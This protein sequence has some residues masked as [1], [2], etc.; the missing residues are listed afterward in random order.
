MATS[1][2]SGG[3][4]PVEALAEEFL[5]RKRRGEPASP[6][7]YAE[8]HP[9]LAEEILVLFPALLMMEDLAGDSGGQTGSL[10]SG[11][12]TVA[13]ATAGRLGEF[14]LLREVGRGGMGVVY[15][16]EQESLGRRVALKVLPAGALVDAKQV[17]RFER[18]ARSAARLHHTNIVPVFGV[19]RHEGTHFYVMQF[20]Q[21]QGL[22]AVLDELRR[23][24]ESRDPKSAKAGPPI[25]AT[26]SLRQRD[27]SEIARS[28]AT[29]RF[30]AGLGHG[31]LPPGTATLPWS[32]AGPQPIGA[33]TSASDLSNSAATSGVTTLPETDRRFALGV[34]RIGVQ[35]AEALAYAH[36]QGIL[37]RDI[38]PSNLLLDRDGNVW[39][40]DFG[41]AKATGGEDLTHTGDVVG[42]VRYMAPERFR[43]EGD[44]RAD[45]YS[46][47]LTLYE[48]LALRPAFEEKD[49]AA[50]VRQVTQEDPPRL[51]RLNGRV[52]ADLETIVHKAIAREPAQRYASAKALAE[53]LQ[54]FLE[55]RPILARRV[56]P[57]ERAWRWCRRNPA[58]AGLLG[59]VA[60]LVVAGLV[61]LSAATVHLSRT[62]VS[63]R[64]ARQEADRARTEAQAAQRE[65]D[66]RRREAEASRAEAE[67]QSKAAEASFARARAAVDESFTKISESRLLNVAGMQP[68]RRELLQSA[69]AYYEGFLKDHGDDPTVRAGLASAFLHVGKIRG[70]FGQG[71][72][73]RKTLEKARALFE[74]L[75]AANPADPEAAHGL[76]Q[77]LYWL[78][79]P[80]DAI[81]IWERM[82]RPGAPRFQRELAD[83]YNALGVDAS[84][85]GDKAKALDAYQK[86]LVIREML[87]GLDTGDP[88][89][90]RDLGGCLNNIGVL[91][92]NIGQPEQALALYRRGAQQA[93]EAFARAPQD[94]Q[95]G[96]FLALGLNNCAELEESLG[97]RDEATRL[98]RGVIEICET[99]VRDNPAIPWLR[100]IL[101]QAY[102]RLAERFRARGQADEAR[103]TIRAG[104]ER[105]ERLPRAG[106]EDLYTL[107]SL[108]AE[109][110][111]WLSR[112][113]SDEP[114]E[115]ERAEQ[116]RQVDLAMDALRRAA[117]A[118]I[119][120]V[121]QIRTSLP[122]RALRKRPDFEA[123]VAEL[124]REIAAPK[125]AGS[126]TPGPVAV[127]GPHRPPS[128]AAAGRSA[129]GQENQAAARHAVGLVLLD[130]GRLDAAAEHLEQ[131]LAVRRALVEA[132]PEGLA[133]QTDL[134]AT[135]AGLARLDRKAGR[136]ER[137]RQSWGQA[138]PILA[139]AV[140][141]RPDDRLAWRDLG[142]TRAELGQAEAAAAFARLIEL[143]PESDRAATLMGLVRHA[144]EAGW[145]ERARHWWEEI[146]S[147]RERAVARHPGDREAWR[148]LG[149]AR[150]ELGREDEAV[151]A[152]VKLMELTPESRDP[153]RWWS[154]DPAGI[155]E[156]LAGHDE[157]F[158]RLVRA[159]P[160]D[161]TLL[162]ARFQYLGRRKR[163]KEADEMAGRLVELEP[164]DGSVRTYHRTLLLL[165][166][167][168]EGY[169][170]ATSEALASTASN[171]Q[172]NAVGVFEIFGEFDY[173]RTIAPDR[174]PQVALELMSCG[175]VAYRE[176]RYAEA[177]G[178]LEKGVE[179]HDDWWF[180]TVAHPFMAMA[181]QKLGHD[182]E[183]RRELA[184]ARESYDDCRRMFHDSDSAD[185]PLLRYGW[186]DLPRAAVVLHEAEGVVVYDPAFPADPFAPTDA[187]RS[188]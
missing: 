28:L 26:R 70:E 34:A 79:R 177:I 175:V 136:P 104:R 81:A 44:A 160:R 8:A 78:G 121:E 125:T 178:F 95:I 94:L 180:V 36:G 55:G 82:V 159:R 11:A 43:G 161:R 16:A 54:R 29:G 130:L 93:E 83:A 148:D 2:T 174:P 35:V 89:A 154:A 144:Q 140:E 171:L 119:R 18:E 186:Q 87:V 106:A 173:P 15:E 100:Y 152:F 9:E 96:R 88:I 133:Y 41:L 45:V 60:L 63:E 86:A 97:R 124:R 72:E 21:G 6:E 71:L 184:A 146:L 110:A 164:D 170:R 107:A 56:S 32:A 137:A 48:L 73:A 162:L 10:T 115:A 145:P 141:R 80:E 105:I 183:A 4:N 62:A 37:H 91:L 155:E 51:R 123:F 76:A 25:A 150:A 172:A 33:A 92:S 23:L 112:R 58:V 40:A 134:A 30:A 156:A 165:L 22:D 84:N 181:H 74:P 179:S 129:K 142:I 117:A 153:N 75:V 52:P 13:G 24:R 17:R 59:T 122:F 111:M 66:A 182:A 12:A 128:A 151:A 149:I 127:A 39:V 57:W 7:E 132:E 38:K 114:T 163:W 169:R 101:V 102:H 138:L 77:T 109:S 3:R 168:V 98:S 90:R 64:A 27:A 139:R 126:A 1:T 42:T 68:L 143:T 61:G 157:I 46:L 118:G 166:G 108:R 99:M 167:D 85:R 20:I 116:S 131:A 47:G 158:A 67:T 113:D 50:L 176:G 31:E 147:I 185:G 135:L 19:G 120:D 5:D 14:R 49:R 103:A 188:P 69:L 65:A 53:D 187:G